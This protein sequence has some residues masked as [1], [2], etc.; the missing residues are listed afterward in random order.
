MNF[1]SRLLITFPQFY[2]PFGLHQQAI[3]KSI[4]RFI[5]FLGWLPKTIIKFLLSI[6]N[7]LDKWVDIEE[8][9]DCRMTIQNF[10][11]LVAICGLEI[12]YHER[13]FFR[14]SHEIRYDVKMRKL[15]WL[16]IPVL[17]EIFVSGCTF[18]LKMK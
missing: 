13:Y 9:K 7:Q 2:S 11:K 12:C 3:L 4:L 5:P 14:P 18:I 15:N 1:N 17:E 10:R 8:I 6:T 16:N